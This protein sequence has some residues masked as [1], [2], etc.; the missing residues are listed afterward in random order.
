MQNIV[1]VLLDNVTGFKN[2]KNILKNKTVSP[3]KYTF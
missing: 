3:N 2:L 1:A